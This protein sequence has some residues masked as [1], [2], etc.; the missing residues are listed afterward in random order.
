[1]TVKN[2][3]VVL[4]L[5]GKMMF[6]IVLIRVRRRTSLMVVQLQFA[7]LEQREARVRCSDLPPIELCTCI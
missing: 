4:R 3:L 7:R 5:R 2:G 6:M 1:M